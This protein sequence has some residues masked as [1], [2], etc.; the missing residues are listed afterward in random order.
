MK[1]NE[2]MSTD[3]RS[4]FNDNYIHY[5]A[6]APTVA[7]IPGTTYV[8]KI[9]SDKSQDSLKY[10]IFDSTQT[11]LISYLSVYLE[12]GNIAVVSL[13]ST[14]NE[15]QGQGLMSYIYSHIV[16]KDGFLLMSDNQQT[17]EAKKLWKSC[18]RKHFFNIN[19]IDTETGEQHRWVGDEEPWQSQQDNI[20]LIASRFTNEQIIISE[21][22]TCRYGPRADRRRLAMDNPELY[23]PESYKIY[24]NPEEVAL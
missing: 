21:K 19:V 6:N 24:S 15:Y 17:P 1:L 16:L 13:P 5:F 7:K 3:S 14:A 8:L 20:R 12:A 18:F 22:Y 10:G 9:A 4:E 23:G 2:I 11:I